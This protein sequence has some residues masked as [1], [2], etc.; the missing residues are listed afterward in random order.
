M[1]WHLVISV[2]QQTPDNDFC[3]F[4]ISNVRFAF[5]SFFRKKEKLGSHTG[6][7]WWPGDPEVKDDPNDPLTRW[8]NDPVP[9]LGL[10]EPIHNE[11]GSASLYVGWSDVTESMVTIW[12]PF[13]GITRR[14]VWS[15]KAMI[16]GVIR[17]K[18]NQLVYDNVH[19]ITSLPP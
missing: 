7:K 5:W 18:L 6:S 14:I 3:H 10:I 1:D 4:S 9:Y 2:Q 17:I 11:R 13:L 15:K 19:T 12:S 16:C 8:P